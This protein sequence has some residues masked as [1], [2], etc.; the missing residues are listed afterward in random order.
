MKYLNLFIYN[1]KQ[2]VFSFL[3]LKNLINVRYSLILNILYS[4]KNIFSS[5]V[6]KI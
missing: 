2:V 1:F 3:T 6:S 5:K 4:T